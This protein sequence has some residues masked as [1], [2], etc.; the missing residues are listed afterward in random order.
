[1]DIWD[2]PNCPNPEFSM[3]SLWKECNKAFELRVLWICRSI[4]TCPLEA[5][6][7]STTWIDVMI[8]GGNPFVFFLPFCRCIFLDTLGVGETKTWLHIVQL[9]QMP[10]A[11]QGLPGR[12]AV[13]LWGNLCW[14]SILWLPSCGCRAEESFRP[15]AGFDKAQLGPVKL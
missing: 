5:S 14:C 7:W 9:R 8:M 11:Y 10:Q 2:Y 6:H 13:F 4:S 12:W 1:M 3:V 15:L